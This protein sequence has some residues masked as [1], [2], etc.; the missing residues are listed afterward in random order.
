MLPK[1]FIVFVLLL[2][3]V[4]LATALV[5]LLKDRER[6]PRTVKALTVRIAISLALFFLL[7]LGYQAGIL[8]PHGLKAGSTPAETGAVRK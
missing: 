3:I 1:I 7:L 4:S 8:R 5:Y 6:S 2:I